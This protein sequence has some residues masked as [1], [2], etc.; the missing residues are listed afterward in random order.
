MPSSA[1]T[2]CVPRAVRPV[3]QKLEKKDVPDSL[4]TL[5]DTKG[6]EAGSIDARAELEREIDQARKS[7]NVHDHVHVRL[8][9]HRLALAAR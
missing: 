8:A 4:L 7:D 2:L 9:V 5:W 1:R 6:V 3:T